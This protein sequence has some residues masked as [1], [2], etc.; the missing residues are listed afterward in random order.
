MQD[1][2]KGTQKEKTAEAAKVTKG[3]TFKQ[4]AQHKC[5]GMKQVGETHLITFKGR[6][7]NG[8]REFL[9]GNIPQHN[10]ERRL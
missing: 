3:K 7:R 9:V 5:Q 6:E 1:E 10:S 8:D 4:S 2:E